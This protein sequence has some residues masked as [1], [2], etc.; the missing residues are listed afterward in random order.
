MA[1]R[2]RNIIPKAPLARVLTSVGAKRV[3]D[4]A[5]DVFSE[6]LAD[7]GGDIAAQ[8]AKIARHSGRKTV[9]EG[10]IMLA[11]KQV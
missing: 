10:D 3:S 9:M 7:I 6:I 4:K 1:T 11:A 8:A 2:K 5:L